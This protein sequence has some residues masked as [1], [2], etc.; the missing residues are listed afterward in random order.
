MALLPL[1]LIISDCLYI[2]LMTGIFQSYSR[3]LRRNILA[4]LQWSR[5]L[6]I[7]AARALWEEGLRARC[8]AWWRNWA[9]RERRCGAEDCSVIAAVLADCA[10]AGANILGLPKN[11][12]F[13]RCCPRAI[14]RNTH[15]CRWC[16]IMADY[17]RQHFASCPDIHEYNLHP[18]VRKTRGLDVQASP[19]IDPRATWWRVTHPQHL[20]DDKGRGA[21]AA[22][23]TDGSAGETSGAAQ[24][25]PPRIHREAVTDRRISV[26]AAQGHTANRHPG[27]GGGGGPGPRPAGLVVGPGT[28]FGDCWA[29]GGAGAAAPQLGRRAGS[30]AKAAASAGRAEPRWTDCSLWHQADGRHAGDVEMETWQRGCYTFGVSQW[31]RWN[32][33]FL[34]WWLP[35]LAGGLWVLWWSFGRVGWKPPAV[36]WETWRPYAEG[37][38]AVWDVPGSFLGGAAH[39]S[40]L[41]W[42]PWLL[43]DLLAQVGVD[44]AGASLLQMFGRTWCLDFTTGSHRTL[45]RSRHRRGRGQFSISNQQGGRG[46]A[47][48]HLLFPGL[49]WRPLRHHRLSG[50]GGRT[51]HSGTSGKDQDQF[52]RRG[53]FVQW[54]S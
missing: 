21:A 37:G 48:V 31:T 51:L 8:P 38:T 40:A 50:L 53:L 35:A 46:T 27:G 19:H 11:E 39:D 32:L 13:Q 30:Q 52:L 10:C 33:E 29:A 15:I 28:T 25:L 47:A 23:S 9:Q 22:G 12:C 14:A 41:P 17:C 45:V 42:S 34:G 7:D 54:M 44:S 18:E 6:S 2:I 20:Q 16:Q 4:A 5:D 24:Q 36:Q 3:K 43:S 49:L 26:H 1:D